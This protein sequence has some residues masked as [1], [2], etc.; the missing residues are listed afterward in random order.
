MARHACARPRLCLASLLALA[1]LTSSCSLVVDDKLSAKP[2]RV[3][4][5]RPGADAA[6]DARSASQPSVDP[7]RGDA[8]SAPSTAVPDAATTPTTPSL[9]DA[10]APAAGSE[11]GV[12]SSPVL[13]QLC[14]GSQHGCALAPSGVITCWGNKDWGQLALDK[15]PERFVQLSCGDNH[16]CAVTTEHKLVCVGSNSD[17]QTLNAPQ[18]DDYIEVAAGALHTCARKSDGRVMCWGAFNSSTGEA[19]APTDRFVAIAAGEDVSCGILEVDHS[20]RC[21]GSTE[22]ARNKPPLGTGFSALDL[23]GGQGCAIDRARALSCWGALSDKVPPLRALRAVS[24]GASGRGCAQTDAELV[25][26]YGAA[27]PRSLGGAA[28]T[29]AAGASAVC[30]LPSDG[31]QL[32][33]DT[34]DL[35]DE[36][37]SVPRPYPG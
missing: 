4:S 25:C 31:G 23:G 22:Q 16:T 19:M 14:V 8:A 7:Q 37:K 27:E 11:A 29:F 12:S 17:K 2:L 5:T 24:V 3:D 32:L 1:A 28:A 18:D 15:R 21:W 30:T 35:D 36:L 10:G 26:W 9:S 13:S 33:C 6:A 34:D 20:I